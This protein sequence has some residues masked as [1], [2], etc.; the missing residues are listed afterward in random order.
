MCSALLVCATLAGCAATPDAP[1]PALTLPAQWQSEA[2]WRAAQPGD[3]EPKGPWWQAFGDAPLDALE[4]RA[5]ADNP[6]LAIAQARLT[7]ARATLAATSAA[8]LPQ[9]G[10][11]ERASRSRI[12]ANRPLSNYKSPNFSTIQNDLSVAMAVNYEVDLAG[13]TSLA[14]TGAQATVEQAGADLENIRLLL[15]ADLATAY[16]NLRAVD[17]E[18]DVLD[19]AIALQR[20]A[21]DL[22]SARHDLGAA[23]GLDV[24]QQQALIDATRVQVDGLRRQRGVFEHAVATLS[25]IPAPQFT[26]AA[27]LRAVPPPTIAVGL[28]SDLLERRPDIAS[29]ERAMAAANA[30]IGVASAAAYPSIL[31]GGGGGVD[32]RNLASLLDAPSLLWSLGASAAQV[33]FDGGRIA[34]GVAAARANHAAAAANYRRV[35]LAAMQEVEDGITGISSLDN[36][37]AQARTAVDS[38]GRVLTMVNARHDGGAAAYSEVI[39]AQQALLAAERQATQLDGQRRVT[40]VFLVKALGG[41]WRRPGSTSAGKGANDG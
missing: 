6:T 19:R 27:D 15:T 28:P 20:R 22:I 38:A 35:V 32:S 17:A 12:S 11:S 5:L 30:Q 25:G 16:F 21:L 41:D 7:Q 2:P 3:G 31:L 24:A 34:A 37:A 29:A 13:R 39:T 26:L 40:A 8:S 14:I 23:T 4:A 1:P 18:L 9:I 36:A 10:L 33:L